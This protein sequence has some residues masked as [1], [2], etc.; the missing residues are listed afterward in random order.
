MIYLILQ[1]M[2]GSLVLHSMFRVSNTPMP[3]S[4]GVSS[5]TQEGRNK[6]A[7]AH[8]RARGYT[9]RLSRDVLHYPSAEEGKERVWREEE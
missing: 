3:D 5:D 4:L 2:I 8:L 7:R 9:W 1:T 6:E